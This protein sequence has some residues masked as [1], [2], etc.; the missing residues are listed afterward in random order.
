AA[1]DT[2]HKATPLG[3]MQKVVVRGATLILDDEGTGRH[4]RADSVDATLERN[5]EGV[6]GDLSMAIPI[7]ARAT[8]IHAS[9]RY[10]SASGMLDFALEFGAVDPAAF[11]SLAPD[12]A[13]LAALD[14]PVPG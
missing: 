13:P 4:W 6:A 5:P 10:W 14:V 1:A 3:A 8:E 2:S 9:Y 7:G 12:L 11:V